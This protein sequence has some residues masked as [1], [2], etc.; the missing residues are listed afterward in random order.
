MSPTLRYKSASFEIHA[1]E[2]SI[3]A[4]RTP[5]QLFPKANDALVEK[6]R[7]WLENGLMQS[8][9]D[10]LL[11]AYRSWL[12]RLPEMNILF[13]L[14]TGEDKSHPA[15]PD[16]NRAK[17]NWLNDLGRAGV[18]PSDIDIVAVSH[19][20]LDHVGWLTRRHNQIWKPTFPQARHLVTASE[21]DFWTKSADDYSWMGESLKE[22][23]S[24]IYEADLFET[25][26][27]DDEIAEGVKTFC[28][29][30][31]SP[32]MMGMMIERDG[33]RC[34]MAA[35]VAHHPLQFIEPQLSTSFCHDPVKAEETRRNFISRHV[36]SGDLIFPIHFPIPFGSLV[37]N[38]GKID[39]LFEGPASNKGR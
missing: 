26:A 39:F 15:R 21:L 25:V 1:I 4:A 8:P 36:N 31:H 27:L 9:G 38:A 35:D 20:H 11:L 5:Q 29:S 34:V 7:H 24:P 6:H 33:V 22:S 37:S 28:L 32:G 16:L 23:I 12:I 30:G 3:H 17:T 18:A 2:D 13:D 19:L 14:S 10:K